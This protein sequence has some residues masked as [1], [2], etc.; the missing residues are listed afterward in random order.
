MKLNRSLIEGYTTTPDGNL[1]TSF[2]FNLFD[3]IVL[4][5]QKGVEKWYVEVRFSQTLH[6]QF[7]TNQTVQ[8]YSHMINKLENNISR[9]LIYSFQKER[10]DAFLEGRPTQ[11]YFNYYYF[12]DR[13]RFRTRKMESTL[14]QIET[15]LDEFVERDIL[16]DSYKRK[17]TGFNIELKPLS[18]AEINDYFDKTHR[19]QS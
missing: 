4:R 6:E 9:I 18:E 1:Q 7:T 8:I 12:T 5:K 17:G 15:A 14:K 19:L 13:V 16:V 10:L 3:S 11:R 2:S